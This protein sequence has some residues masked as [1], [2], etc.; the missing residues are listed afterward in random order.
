MASFRNLSKPT[1]Y[2]L[3]AIHKQMVD[4]NPGLVFQTGALEKQ[5]NSFGAIWTSP[6]DFYLVKPLCYKERRVEVKIPSGETI[7]AITWDT[8][9]CNV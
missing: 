6:D 3:S 1:Y 5:S 7:T 4:K 9:L 2:F 8:D